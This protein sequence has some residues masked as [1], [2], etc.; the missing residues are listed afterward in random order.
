VS[1]HGLEII[2]GFWFTGDHNFILINNEWIAV[3]NYVPSLDNPEGGAGGGEKTKLSGARAQGTPSRAA[4]AAGVTAGMAAGA[5]SLTA[6]RGVESPTPWDGM[7]GPGGAVWVGGPDGTWISKD[8]TMEVR[9]KQWVS[10]GGNPD[11]DGDA[12]VSHEGGM[13]TREAYDE[14]IRTGVDPPFVTQSSPA[15]AG[16]KALPPT[17]G[18]IVNYYGAPVGHAGTIPRPLD[19][20]MPRPANGAIPYMGGGKKSPHRKKADPEYDTKSSCSCCGVS[21]W[22]YRVRKDKTKR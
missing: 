16:G 22:K 15:G 8:G 14:F 9:N 3:G 12:L 6:T 5:A 7:P 2:N 4:I 11:D 21:L 1:K 20:A 13:I 17:R 18:G 10:R 19:G